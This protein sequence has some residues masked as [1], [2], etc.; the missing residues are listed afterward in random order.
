MQKCSVFPVGVCHWWV[1]GT[2]V[3]VLAVQHFHA[4]SRTG[5]HMLM[6][7]AIKVRAP[8][9]NCRGILV[10]CSVRKEDEILSS[11]SLTGK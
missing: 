7:M 10:C 11:Q 2:G 8:V 3:G 4:S 9:E 6:F 5:G 1:P